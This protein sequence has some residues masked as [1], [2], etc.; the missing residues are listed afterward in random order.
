MKKIKKIFIY[1]LLLFPLVSCKSLQK[2]LTPQKKSGSEEFLV[3][4]KSPLVMPPSYN[5]LPVPKIN[6]NNKQKKIDIKEMVTGVESSNTEK[7]ELNKKSSVEEL[8]LKSIKKN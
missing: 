3:E 6:D 5:Q 4:K 8:I 1:F 2:S 7:K